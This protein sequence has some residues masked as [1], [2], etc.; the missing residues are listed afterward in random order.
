MHEHLQHFSI[1]S[2]SK[3]ANRFD[4]GLAKYSSQYCSR[5]FGFVSAFKPELEGL[6]IDNVQSNRFRFEKGLSQFREIEVYA[7]NFLKPHMLVEGNAYIWGINLNY[8]R[9]STAN[10]NVHFYC[11][12]SNER[13]SEFVFSKDTYLS[14][15]DFIERHLMPKTPMTLIIT[16]SSHADSIKKELSF[17]HDLDFIVY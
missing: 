13:K 15:K 17:R 11:I 10:P 7:V 14:I 5:S 3:L 1:N 2:L 6:S 12:D 16:A 8:H 4:F 9:L